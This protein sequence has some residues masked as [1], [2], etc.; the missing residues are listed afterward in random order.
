[1]SPSLYP[2][3]ATALNDPTLSLHHHHPSPTI[4]TFPYHPQINIS[5]INS[6]RTPHSNRTLLCLQP[7]FLTPSADFQI[8]KKKKNNRTFFLTFLF[9]HTF[10][11]ATLDPI[12]FSLLPIF[13]KP[14]PQ[15]QPHPQQHSSA[16]ATNQFFLTSFS[17]LISTISNHLIFLTP[18]F[19][20]TNYFF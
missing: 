8:K 9:P 14:Q 13:F 1:M 3:A 18:I 17:L 10:S 5:A 16:T 2:Y 20:Y 7:F 19:F 12:F 4:P 15:Q 11:S 6:I